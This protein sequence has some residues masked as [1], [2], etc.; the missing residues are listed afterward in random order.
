MKK[1]A[2]FLVLASACFEGV[3]QKCYTSHLSNRGEDSLYKTYP[4]SRDSF[5]REGRVHELDEVDIWELDSSYAEPWDAEAQQWGEATSKAI[6][7][8]DENDKPTLYVSYNRSSP[9]EKW[10]PLY[11]TLYIN[12]Y[13]KKEVTEVIQGWNTTLDAWETFDK[14]GYWQNDNGDNIFFKYYD[15]STEVEDWVVGYKYIYEYNERGKEVLAEGFNWN[16]DLN[17]WEINKKT[18]TSYVGQS[19]ET[20]SYRW[21]GSEWVTLGKGELQFDDNDNKVYEIYSNY[22]SENDQWTN[23]AKLFHAYNEEGKRLKYELYTWDISESKWKGAD[24]YTIAYNS[25]GKDSSFVRYV[26]DSDIGE[27]YLGTKREYIYNDDKLATEFIVYNW[28]IDNEEWEYTS[29]TRQFFSKAIDTEEVIEDQIIAYGENKVMGSFSKEVAWALRSYTGEVIE[30]GRFDG[31]VDA[32]QIEVSGLNSGI[33][34]L[35]I[36]DGTHS[37]DRKLIIR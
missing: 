34:L 8:T 1:L 13:E 9:V 2:L 3:G 16:T 29:R 22:D 27:W 23:T 4:N 24:N 32:K 5:V 36:S 20:F 28:N 12:D 21:N 31:N 33:Y 7:E 6:R 15:W 25:Y 26:W 14:Y 10:Q 19:G 17:E 30:K 18:E 37:V 11:R 35:N